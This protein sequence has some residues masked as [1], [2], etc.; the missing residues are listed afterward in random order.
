MFSRFLALAAVLA[1][2]TAAAAQQVQPLRVLYAGQPDHAR[3]RAFTALLAERF[4]AVGTVDFRALDRAAAEG[5]DVVVYDPPTDV[6]YETYRDRELPA[7]FDRPTV[8]V[9]SWAAR[10]AERAKL[11]ISDG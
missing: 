8:L 9:G 3:E 10:L 4:A 5:W 1:A 2:V 6:G 11:K 7:D